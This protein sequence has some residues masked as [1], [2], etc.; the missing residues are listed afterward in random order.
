MGAL[1]GAARSRAEE[2]RR[3]ARPPSPRGASL[4]PSSHRPPRAK[5]RTARHVTAL[6]LVTILSLLDLCRLAARATQRRRHPPLPGGRAARARARS[7][8]RCSWP[9]RPDRYRGGSPEL[10]GESLCYDGRALGSRD[11]GGAVCW[12]G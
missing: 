11:R 8:T 4:A 1:L 2:G 6:T 12:P 3:G 7:A 9:T 10:D 5:Q